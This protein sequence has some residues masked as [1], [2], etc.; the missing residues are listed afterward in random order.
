MGK[1]IR[2]DILELVSNFQAQIKNKPSLP[3]MSTELQMMKFKIRPIQGDFSAVDLKDEDFI[4]A[5]W[6]LGKLDEFFQKEIVRLSKKE[7]QIFIKIFDDLY[8]Q[9]QQELN[10]VNI[11]RG[12]PVSEENKVLEMEIFKEGKGNKIN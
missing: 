4:R 6:S 11:Y 7:R 10:R 12:E 9:Y 3:Q 2:R 1:K 8:R 5:L